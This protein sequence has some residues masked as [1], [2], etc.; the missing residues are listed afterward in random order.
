MLLPPPPRMPG[1]ALEYPTRTRRAKRW[2]GK[3][4]ATGVAQS[5]HGAPTGGHPTPPAK[6]PLGEKFREP[7]RGTFSRAT[8][9][10]ASP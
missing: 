2:R 4:K 6:V 7:M 5:L 1:D 3:T 8:T 10:M 9:S